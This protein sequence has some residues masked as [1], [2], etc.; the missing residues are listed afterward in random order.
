MKYHENHDNGKVKVFADF[1]KS[2]IFVDSDQTDQLILIDKPNQMFW[3]VETT[4]PSKKRDVA[5]QSIFIAGSKESK[6]STRTKVSEF[7][8]SVF[9]RD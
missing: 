1:S 4:L 8:I 3:N 5:D 9:K 6:N 7:K 2:E